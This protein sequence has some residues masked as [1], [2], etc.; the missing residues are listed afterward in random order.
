MLRPPDQFHAAIVTI[1]A[2]CFHPAAL[3]HVGDQEAKRQAREFLLSAAGK[4]G[5]KEAMRSMI[6][7][8]LAQDPKLDV[9]VLGSWGCGA[10]KC[11]WDLIM[12]YFRDVIVETDAL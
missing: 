12:T 5:V 3:G 10:Y 11:D 8:P 7:T 2:P 1:A 4:E 9:I 6:L